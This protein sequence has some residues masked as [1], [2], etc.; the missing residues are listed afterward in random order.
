MLFTVPPPPPQWDK[1]KDSVIHS[2]IS[3]FAEIELEPVGL[4]FLA[5][6]RRHRTQRTLAQDL[7][8]EQALLEATGDDLEMEEDEPETPSLLRSDP[9]KWKVRSQT[10]I[11]GG[12][13]SNLG[14]MA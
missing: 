2:K 12:F 3:A 5:R 4:E 1:T 7:E 9:G 11:S 14:A 10:G 6:I 13:G 8:M